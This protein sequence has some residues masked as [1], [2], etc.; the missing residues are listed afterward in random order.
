MKQPKTLQAAIIFYA[1]LD[2]C[3]SHLVAQRWG[4]KF[5]DMP[6]KALS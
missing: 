3:L 6:Y 1:D 4:V 5:Q 2:N